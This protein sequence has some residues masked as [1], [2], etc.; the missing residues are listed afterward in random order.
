VKA[1]LRFYKPYTTILILVM[2]CTFLTSAMDLVFPMAVRFIMG[3]VLPAGNLQQLFTWSGILLCLY[4]LHY[5]LLYFTNYKGHVMSASIENDMRREL[6]AHLQNMSFNFFD[7]AKTGQLLSRLTSDIAEV[8]ELAFLAPFD[9][10]VCT[11]TMGGTLVL[12]LYLNLKLG[13]IIA[14]LLILKTIH[15]I[16][17]NRKMKKAFRENRVKNAEISAQAEESLGGIRIVKAFAQEAYELQQFVQRNQEY[18]AARCE[19]YKILGNF[20][21][22][23]SFFTN[24]TNLIVLCL[25]GVMIAAHEI[26]VSDFV[27]YLLYVSVFMRPLFRLTVFTEMYQRGMAGFNRFQELMAQPPQLAD[28]ET[29]P[30]HRQVQG[31]IEF[32]HVWFGY[33]PDRPVLK[34]FNLKV[35]RGDTVAFVGETGAGKTTISNILL[36]FYDVQQGAV[37]VDGVDVRDYRQQDLRKQIGLVQQDVFMFSD[38]VAHNIAYGD[39]DA[40]RDAIQQ[41]A[42]NAA[43]LEFIARLPQGLDTEIGERGVKL[44]GGQKQRIAIARVFLKNPPIVVL[45][46]ATSSLDNKTEGLIQQDLDKLAHNRTTLVI[47]HRLSTVQNADRIVVLAGGRVAEIGSHEELMARRGLYYDL[48]Q[49][50]Q[51]EHAASQ[52]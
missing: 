12:L 6:F 27:A 43:A 7:N 41:A 31:E 21:S 15:T 29:A 22:S 11:L 14:L 48:Y 18:L 8:G 44:S 49:A 42:R 30:A 51:K 38:S 19:S 24:I 33:L 5:L 13:L 16:W 25:G 52:E 2:V 1:F 10:I 39:F 17:I 4:L 40:D 34:D 36:R 50:Q 3:S 45:D 35:A 20:S 47:A 9:F 26:Q 28:K 46:E 37:K 32:A 23:I